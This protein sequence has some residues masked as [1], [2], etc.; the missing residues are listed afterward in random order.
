MYTVTGLSGFLLRV[1]R[2]LRDIR[3]LVLFILVTAHNITV[4]IIISVII[5]S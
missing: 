5:K 2:D 1:V 4:I 3:I